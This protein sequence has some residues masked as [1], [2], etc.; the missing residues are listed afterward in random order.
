MKKEFLKIGYI[1]EP[2]ALKGALKIRPTTSFIAER[3]EV[4]NKVF[5]RNKVTD[6]TIT[7][8]ITSVRDQKDL[9]IVTFDEIKDID[10]AEE[11]VKGHLFIDKNAV[12]LA[13][14]YFY[15][16]DL[17]GMKVI[18]ENNTFIGEVVEILEYAAYNTLRVRREKGR[19]LLIPYIAEFIIST[20]LECKTIVFRPIEGML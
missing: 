13:K 11:F 16:D 2:H 3:F 12:K 18:L 17:I 6:E 5:A 9:L 7:L 1:V 15:F 4:G 10:T 8:T 20:D 14:G 19:D